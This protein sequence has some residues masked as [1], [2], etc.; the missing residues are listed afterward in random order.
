MDI[1]DRL[2]HY[3]T[4]ER[5]IQGTVMNQTLENPTGILLISP[6]WRAASWPS[7]SLACLKAYLER[8]GIDITVRHMHMEMA[9]VLGQDRYHEIA[10]RTWDFAEAVYGCLME[11]EEEERLLNPI[12]DKLRGEGRE[13]AE[14]IATSGVE[15]VARCT[16]NLLAN[17]DL[18]K[19]GMVGLSVG[20]LQLSSSLYLAKYFKEQAPH[21][22]IL[23]GGG[24]VVG[25]VNTHLL[26]AEP[27]VD[28]IIDGEGEEPFVQFVRA[29]MTLDPEVLAGIPNLRFRAADGSIQSTRTEALPTMD[30]LP[31][32]DYSD[33]F[34]AAAELGYPKSA[35]VLPIEASRGCA[36]EHRC[37]DGEVRGCTFCGLF[38]TSPNYREKNLGRLL[39]EIDELVTEHQ[40]LDLSFV[41]AYLPDSYD[42]QLL[43]A[44]GDYGDLTLWCELRCN[45]DEE[46]VALLARA[47]TRK[48]QLGIESFHT[49]M[50]TRIEKGARAIDNI[51]ALKLCDEYRIRYQYNVLTY[52]PGVPRQEIEE[53]LPILPLLYGYRPPGVAEFYLDRGSRV[54]MHPELH[55]LRPEDLD[56]EPIPYLPSRLADKK[57]TEFVPFR[58]EALP[59]GAAEAWAEVHRSVERWQALY[60]EVTA[61]GFPM[62]L[63]YREG[64]DFVEVNDFRSG[65]RQT[66]TFD[67]HLREIFLA[68]HKPINADRLGRQLPHIPA[69]RIES[70][71]K[72]LE[73]RGLVFREGR[74]NLALPSRLI[75]P[76][77]APRCASQIA[78]RFT[79]EVAAAVPAAGGTHVIQA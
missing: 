61:T 15:D 40:K 48:I 52:Y 68:C 69:E 23:M 36:W 38:R 5:K 18:S 1:R 49:G 11:P 30:E 24:G 8:E 62:L 26:E 53:M 22:K 57:I 73:S 35:I 17:I 65:E 3:P 55:D 44:L 9:C 59:E 21:I 41:D 7:T 66:L 42:R 46:T 63:S 4:I 71:L 60:D 51:Y 74:L 33:Y 47:G 37:G 64:K 25:E 34:T 77:G 39:D 43:A 78:R 13:I 70:L 50:L 29:G 14:W 2:F 76:N 75:L 28:L 16:R 54:Y 56:H 10:D 79:S 45:L 32:P 20:A 67:G 19:L 72:A 12:V 31:I 58:L 6:P 27:N